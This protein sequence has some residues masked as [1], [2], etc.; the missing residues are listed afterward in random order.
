MPPR[1]TEHRRAAV[2][3]FSGLS[4][5]NAGGVQESGRIAWRAVVGHA[6]SLGGSAGLLVYGE[7]DDAD[8]GLGGGLSLAEANRWCLLGKAAVRQWHTPLACFWHTGLLRL[9]PVLRLGRAEIVLFLHGVEA[10]RPQG[11]LTQRLLSRVDRFLS[12]SSFTWQRF[13]EFQPQL[14]DRPH[15]V[16]PLGIGEPVADEPPPPDDPPAVLMLGRLQR[17]EDYKGHRE[18]IAAWPRVRSQSPGARLWVAGDGDLRPDLEA[19]A[20]RCGVSDAVRFWG[21]VSESQKQELLRRSRCMAMPSRGEGFGLVYL[22]AMRLGRPCLVSTCDAGQEVVAPPEAGLAADPGRPDDLTAALVRL[23]ADGPDWEERS[24]AARR[25]YEG[26]FT[27]EQF[28][29]RLLAALF[30]PRPTTAS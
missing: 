21:R 11:W 19:L 22:E 27:A 1:S 9:L 15:A 18:I 24:R 10:W 2:C 3:L 20:A 6:R 4:G 7:A 29:R 26:A 13:L 25:R 28:Q 14:A 12:N 23:L 30:G 17:G 16:V 5:R 8:L